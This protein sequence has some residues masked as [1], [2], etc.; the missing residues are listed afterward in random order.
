M[1]RTLLFL[2]LMG[3]L[4]VIGLG[5]TTDA[6]T[7]RESRQADREVVVFAEGRETR[8]VQA[9]EDAPQLYALDLV[10]RA[11]TRRRQMRLRPRVL[12]VESRPPR[13]ISRRG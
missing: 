9:T 1:S 8:R 12:P 7:N 5:Q 13:A 3:S 2:A 11:R 6:S 10:E 4:P